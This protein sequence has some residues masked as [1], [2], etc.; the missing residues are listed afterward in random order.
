MRYFPPRR[1]VCLTEETV[2]TLYLLGE[3]DRIVGVSGYAVRPPGV[4][5]EKPRVSAFI[6]ADI[7]KILALEPDL[8]LAF[9]DLQANIVA[10]LVRAGVAVHVFNQRDIAGILAMIRTLGAM[11]GAAERADQLARSF[12][13]RL[14]RIAATPRASPRPKVYF[15]EWDDPLISGIGWVSELIEIAGGEDALPELRFQH[16]AKDRIIAPDTVRDAAPDVILASWCGKKVVPERIRQ[17][18]GWGGI[19]AVR[20]NRIVEIKSTIILQPG[21]A[22]LT[23]GLDA[24]VRALWPESTV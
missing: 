14:A 1:I 8:V 7:P 13:E 20:N 6:S 19:P 18:P 17:R 2:E 3:Q 24:I 12:Q 21:P 9:S 22:A 15:E 16:A 10:D 23:D 4:R 5:R 11:V